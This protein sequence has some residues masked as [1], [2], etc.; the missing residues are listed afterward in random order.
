MWRVD[1]SLGGQQV[2]I[3]RRG[4]SKGESYY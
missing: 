2:F 3:D 1:W 4:R